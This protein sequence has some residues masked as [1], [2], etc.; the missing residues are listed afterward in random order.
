[1]YAD[2]GAF[3]DHDVHRELKRMGVIHRGGEWYECTPEQVKAAVLAVRMHIH[4]EEN[5]TQTFKMR[6]EQQKAVEKTVEYFKAQ[7]KESTNRTPKFLWNAKCVLAR[8]LLPTN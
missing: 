5:R 8:P 3:N 2:G 1:M 7:E 6:P 4:N